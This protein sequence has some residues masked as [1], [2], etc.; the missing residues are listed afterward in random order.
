VHE[1]HGRQI[2]APLAYGG[3]RLA[4]A[5]WPGAR[6]D[7]ARAQHDAKGV[8]LSVVPSLLGG[9]PLGGQA[10]GA[11]AARAGLGLQDLIAALSS[12]VTSAAFGSGHRASIIVSTIGEN[13]RAQHK[14][15][16]A[17]HFFMALSLGV[18]LQSGA[19][20]FA[21]CPW[22]CPGTAHE[23]Q[24]K[25]R[26]EVL[27]VDMSAPWADVRH[28]LVR[29][30]GLLLGHSTSHCFADFNHVDCC[31]MVAGNTHRT[32]EES[33]IAGMHP[34]NQLE[35]HIKAA[36]V[37]SHSEGGSWCTCH[38][39]SPFD[40]CHRQF[41][42]APAL[43][44]VWCEGD[45]LAVVVDDSGNVLTSG[46]PSLAHQLISGDSSKAHQHGGSSHG[47]DP[48]SHASSAAFPEY[49]GARARRDNWA[50]LMASRNQTMVSRWRGACEQA[51]ADEQRRRPA[52]GSA[53]A[54]EAQQRQ[55]GPGSA[56]A[57]RA[58][59]AR[60][61]S[62]AAGAAAAAATAERDEL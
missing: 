56:A 58:T 14:N 37:R 60:A 15:A 41:G 10:R 50:V 45:A 47:G 13:W 61:G 39:Q 32:N 7:A 20:Q 42:A 1:R 46:Y 40:V 36:S 2:S 18:L 44:L 23:R 11:A 25:A 4:A 48:D 3:V 12:L 52:A 9:F 24:S 5:A 43:K 62:L 22:D 30:C 59:S 19:A 31:T 35:N 17:G 6:V 34:V 53:G 29:A 57:G 27:R 33:R 55:P 51:R 38:L 21:D 28:G 16:M 54:A 26:A 49:G 8:G